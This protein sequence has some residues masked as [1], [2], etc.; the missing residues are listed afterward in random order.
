MSK[1]VDKHFAADDD[2]PMDAATVG[3]M[4]AVWRSLTAELKRETA[5][6]ADII[7]KSYGDSGLGLEF[8]PG[9]VDGM[10]KRMR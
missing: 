4:Q 7:A 9:D 10:C 3:L 6:D 1:R 5:R 8:G 2:A